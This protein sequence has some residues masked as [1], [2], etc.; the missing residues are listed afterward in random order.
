MAFNFVL[1]ESFDL[2]CDGVRLSFGAVSEQGSHVVDDFLD[3]VESE[4]RRRRRVLGMT[5]Y[6]ERGS[7]VAIQFRRRC[8]GS[9]KPETPNQ[10]FFSDRSNRFFTIRDDVPRQLS[11][12]GVEFGRFPF[13]VM[14]A[15]RGRT[16]DHLF[17]PD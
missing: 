3:Y 15:V 13:T 12:Y 6:G 8:E 9:Y 5:V 2:F 10:T 7:V 11:R 17:G 4:G 16:R 1:Y 14:G